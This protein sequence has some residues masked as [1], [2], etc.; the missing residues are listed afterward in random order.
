MMA[1]SDETVPSLRIVSNIENLPPRWIVNGV[2][3][4]SIFADSASEFDRYRDA[5]HTLFLVNCAAR[6]LL[7]LAIRRL[8]SFRRQPPL[9]ALDFV[10]LLPPRTLF[11]RAGAALRSLALSK[12]DFFLN[13][14]TDVESLRKHYGIQSA[15]CGFVD[16]K[17]NL[18]DYRVDKPQPDGDYILCFGRSLRDFDTFFSALELSSLPGAILEPR[19]EMLREHGSRF[20]PA[21]S[22]L[23]KNLRVLKD[24]GGERSQVDALRGAR[25][26]AIPMVKGRVIAAG[27]STILN[28][29]ALGKA[30]I[31][32][33]GPGVSDIFAEELISV[34]IED[35][36]ALA[37]AMT[38]VWN[39]RSVRESVASSGWNYAMRCGSESDFN[40]RVIQ[41]VVAWAKSQTTAR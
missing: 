21:L 17:A 31:A 4:E 35:P 18:W 34:P 29:M 15:R 20:S 2:S 28:A 32:S 38:L 25:I 7:Q 9:I 8:L 24:D 12:V 36:D 1:H 23:P 5:P 10:V 37:Q 16:F 19:L 39:D 27:I 30:V 6:L 3:G 13:Y 22:S 14:F 26:V 11:A 40:A 33:A 41:A